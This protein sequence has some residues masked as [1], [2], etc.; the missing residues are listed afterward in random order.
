MTFYRLPVEV[1]LITT[2]EKDPVTLSI[3]ESSEKYPHRA[4]SHWYANNIENPTS[5]IEEEDLEYQYQEAV[6][7][8]Y[9]N[10]LH[11]A[12]YDVGVDILEVSFDTSTNKLIIDF[13][14]RPGAKNPDIVCK[15]LANPGKPNIDIDGLEYLIS[16][17]PIMYLAEIHKDGK[18]GYPFTY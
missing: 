7:F 14:L 3:G 16:A 18:V 12:S 5:D 10:N 15:R 4:V 17:R 9:E 6:V 1:N 13:T 8:W 2:N 11:N